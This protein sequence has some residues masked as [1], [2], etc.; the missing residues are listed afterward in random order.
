MLPDNVLKCH[1][2]LLANQTVR[3]SIINKVLER[4]YGKGNPRAQL[5]GM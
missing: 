3:M 4:I 5:V 1:V 2:R